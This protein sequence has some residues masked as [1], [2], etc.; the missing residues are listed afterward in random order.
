[1][2]PL[3]ILV[4]AGSIAIGALLGASCKS[5]IPSHALKALTPIF[6]LSA[7]AIGMVN[8]IKMD[9]LPVVILSI[10]L[11]TLIGELLYIE[12]RTS[13]AVNAL[14]KLVQPEHRDLF[15]TLVVLFCMSGTGIFGS[16]QSGMDGDNTILYSK[17]ILDFFTAF[18]F[19]TLI[20][21]SVALITLPQIFIQGLLYLFAVFFLKSIPSTMLS[22]FQAVGGLITFAIGLRIMQIKHLAVLNTIPSLALVFLI[23]KIWDLFLYM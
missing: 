12:K 20:G 19:A 2:V 6:G 7:L 17:S 14:G 15:L 1:M 23:T 5:L 13:V 21:Y 4:N 16:L 22:N 11:G 3:G 10:I 18:S 9:S 8:V